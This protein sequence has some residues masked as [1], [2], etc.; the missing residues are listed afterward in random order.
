MK[1]KIYE[2]RNS[3]DEPNRCDITEEKFNKLE[4]RSK[5]IIEIFPKI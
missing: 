4:D 5:E 2:I 1:K 3:L